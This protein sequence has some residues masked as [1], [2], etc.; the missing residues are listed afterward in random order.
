LE[1]LMA[2]F[3]Q[4]LNDQYQPVKTFKDQGEAMAYAKELQ[5]MQGGAYSDETFYVI[6]LNVVG[7]Y[8]GNPKA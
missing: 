6:E 3:Y 4:I 7:T 2:K 8:P 5:T 1:Q